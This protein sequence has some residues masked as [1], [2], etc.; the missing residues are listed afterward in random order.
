MA[1][2]LLVDLEALATL[3]A[4]PRKIRARL[5]EHFHKL[6]AFPDRHSDYHEQDRIGRRVEISVVAGYAIHFWIDFADRHVKVVAM[7]PADA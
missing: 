1:Y 7:L 5:L 4:M 3:D 6:R 2:R